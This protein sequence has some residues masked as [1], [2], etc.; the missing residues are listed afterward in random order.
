MKVTEAN[1]YDSEFPERFSWGHLD[2]PKLSSLSSMIATHI[3]KDLVTPSR[4]YV[5]GLRQ[6]LNHLAEIA[7]V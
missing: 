5:P 7:E 2:S 1:D 4:L 3:F 6:A